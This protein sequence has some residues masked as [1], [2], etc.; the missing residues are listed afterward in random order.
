MFEF[1]VDEFDIDGSGVRNEKIFICFVSNVFCG[2][3]KFVGLDE[4]KKVVKVVSG[5]C[6][7]VQ[8]VDGGGE[9]WGVI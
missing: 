5:D 9:D 6:W 7:M 1:C 3:W 4:S 2:L 8:E